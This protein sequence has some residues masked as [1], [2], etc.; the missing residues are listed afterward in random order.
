MPGGSPS[1]AAAR[2]SRRRSTDRVTGFGRNITRELVGNSS[3]GGGGGG[4][5]TGG[6]YSLPL[7]AGAVSRAA[8][9]ASHWDSTRAVDLI[10]PEGTP[11][12]ATQA[13]TVEHYSSPSCGIGVKVKFTST[14]RFTYCHLSSRS[15]GNGARVSAGQRVGYSDDTDN[16]G[17]PHL[18]I[19]PRDGSSNRCPQPYLLAVYDGR[20]PPAVRNLPTTGCTS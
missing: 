20:T 3:G 18:H 1:P 17:T 16:S 13:A 5:G 11:V 12:L 9:G 19:E 7:P 15:V 14:E 8:Y 10:V 4:G 2:T 6:A